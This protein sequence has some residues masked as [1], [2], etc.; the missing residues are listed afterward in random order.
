[1][2]LYLLFAGASE[3]DSA[4]FVRQGDPQSERIQHRL[5]QAPGVSVAAGSS[6]VLVSSFFAFMLLPCMSLSV[7]A[8]SYFMVYETRTFAIVSSS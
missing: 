6:F 3:L 8:I 2:T 7:K 1:M 4:A 5:Q